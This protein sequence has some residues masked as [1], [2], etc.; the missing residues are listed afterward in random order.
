MIHTLIT[1]AAYQGEDPD[2]MKT[3]ID[4]AGP[5]AMAF[6]V[7]LGIALFFLGR[8]LIRQVKRVSPDLPPGPDDLQQA[9]D[10]QVIRDALARGAQTPPAGPGDTG[11]AG[12]T[13]GP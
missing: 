10:R 3:L 13:T 6:V 5:L 2:E 7:T 12:Q 1:I 11:G 4:N 9:E 8:S